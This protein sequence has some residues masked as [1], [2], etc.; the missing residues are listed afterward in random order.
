[1]VMK[2]FRSGSLGISLA[3][4]ASTPGEILQLK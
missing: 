4:F 2:V 1:L 3:S